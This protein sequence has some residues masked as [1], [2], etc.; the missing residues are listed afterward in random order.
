MS[1]K[2]CVTVLSCA[3][4]VL[5]GGE[6][7]TAGAVEREVLQRNLLRLNTQ[8][9]ILAFLQWD[10]T[11]TEVAPNV[12]TVLLVLPRP[13]RP[14]PRPPALLRPRHHPHLPAGQSGRVGRPATA[15]RQRSPG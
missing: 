14:A 5:A 6:H 9:P 15:L 7:A 1:C 10:C 3:H 8:L 12:V 11:Y 2:A 4:H 13:G